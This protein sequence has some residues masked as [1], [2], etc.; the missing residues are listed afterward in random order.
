V[1]WGKLPDVIKGLETRGMFQAKPFGANTQLFEV[2]DARIWDWNN[3][4][5]TFISK[6]P[7]SK[8]SS[9]FHAK[10]L[11]RFAQEEPRPSL[12]G[13]LSNCGG[14]YSIPFIRK[15]AKP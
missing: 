5:G 13:T 8:E 14:F 3:R 1:Q 11:L 9:D 7:I 15:A 6:M 4:F 10:S 2:E 12:K